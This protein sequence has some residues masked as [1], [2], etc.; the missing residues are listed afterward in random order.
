MSQNIKRKDAN[1]IWCA[2]CGL[3]LIENVLAESIAKM[4]WT[5]EN[6]VIVSGIG[7]TARIS[8]YFELDGV[9]TTHGRAIPV[10]EG[11]KIANPDLNVIVISG[12]GDLLGI[13][14]SHV[15][16]TA[17]RNTPIHVFCNQNQTYG[18]TGG[19]LAPT[20]QKGSKT[21]TTPA[22]SEL[23]PVDAHPI[24]ASNEKY[25]YA[26]SSVIDMEQLK[27]ASR[28]SLEW[29]GFSFVEIISTCH[30]NHGRLQGIDTPALMLAEMKKNP[31]KLIIDTK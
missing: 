3:Y 6:T 13:G 19:Q 27:Q 23:P 24:I 8:G 18:M 5:R 16:H 22:G 4:G 2:G 17:R 10:A 14:L 29:D 28:K 31:P 12:D 30:T 7:C 21:K 20:T 11:I 25:F 15:V 1:K 9:H 26:R